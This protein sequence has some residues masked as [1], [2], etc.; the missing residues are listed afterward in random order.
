MRPRILSFLFFLMAGVAYAAGPDFDRDVAPILLT[1]CLECHGAGEPSGKLDLRTR[2]TTLAGG[3]TGPAFVASNP[4]ESFLL[5]RVV[6]GQMPPKKQGKPQPLPAAEVETLRAWIAA[7]AYWPAGRTLDLFEKTTATRGGRDIWSLQAVRMAAVPRV[8][9]A[10]NPVDAFL[11]AKLEERGWSFAPPADRRTLL[12]RV[13]FDLVGL[14]PSAEEVE[15]FERDPAPDAYERIVDRLLASPHYGERWGRH[16]LDV[17]RYAE[18]CGYERDQEKPFAWKYRDW[19]IRALND[20]KPYDRFVVEQLAGDELPDRTEQTLIATGFLRLGTWNDEP[21]DAHEYKYERLEDMVHVTSTAFLGMTVKCARCH[22]HKFDPIRQDDYYRL[23]AAFWAGPIEPG[24][25]G[26][27]GGPDPKLVGDVLAWT[28]VR[29]D[30][31]PLHLLKKGDP[32]RPERVVSPG[33]LS[34]L[35]ALDKPIAPPPSGARTSGRRLAVARWIV[36]PANPLTPRVWVNRLWLHH[37][38]QGLVRSPDNFGFTGEKPTHPELLDW[39]AA[40][41][42]RGGWKTKR[43]HKL[44]VTSHAYRQASLHPR[45]EE[46]AKTDAGNRLLWRAE[47]RRLDAEALRDALLFA[48]GKLDRARLHGPSFLPEISREALEGWSTKGAAWKASPP[49][50]QGRRSVYAFTKRGLLSPLMTTFD[51][52]DT[53]L[54]C[55]QRD[56]TIVAPQALALLNNP[57]IHQQSEA[58]A[59]RA[60]DEPS[61][62]SR[63]TRA[64]RLALSRP[65]RPTELKAALTHLDVQGRRFGAAGDADFLALA[66]VCHALVNTNEF[67]YVD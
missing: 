14:P 9:G 31:P 54:P 46:I 34:L 23:A 25:R 4:A 3:R 63:V 8:E 56:V 40:E 39:L 15:A 59:R 50:E 62:A 52:A 30:P 61:H 60:M 45:Q 1:R 66:S 42:V 36:D 5:E 57:F 13:S 16:W 65:P 27:L 19:V 41:L 20:D 6:K 53:T 12:R 67:I 38:G 11:L 48:S 49:S 44:L 7:G 64:W 55:G 17:A 26:V 32:R 58:L 29:P 47:R 33:H 35:P 10:G 21:N 22:D 51:S 43:I 37:F 2:A 28:D 18:T 24:S